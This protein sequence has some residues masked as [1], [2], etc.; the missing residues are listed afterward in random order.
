MGKP[1]SHLKDTAGRTKTKNELGP[2]SSPAASLQKEARKM[3]THSKFA[4]HIGTFVF[5]S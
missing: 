5:R 4:S 2:P 3:K 1:G